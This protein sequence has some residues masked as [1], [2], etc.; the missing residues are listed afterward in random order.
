MREEICSIELAKATLTLTTLVCD[1]VRDLCPNRSD[2]MIVEFIQYL[3]D[4]KSFYYDNNHNSFMI[5][6]H[7]EP[8]AY[9]S[10]ED[11]D[12]D[13]FTFLSGWLAIFLLEK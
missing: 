4:K 1:C 10:M 6:S 13:I 9:Y 3:R 8:D 12:E 2:D 5:N 11:L 7:L